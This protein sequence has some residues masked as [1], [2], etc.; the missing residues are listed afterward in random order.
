MIR[1][2]IAVA[3]FLLSA[4][5]MAAALLHAGRYASLCF[6]ARTPAAASAT[7]GEADATQ[8]AEKGGRASDAG[9]DSVSGSQPA[10]AD[11]AEAPAGSVAGSVAKGGGVAEAAA[12]E[13]RGT[14]VPGSVDSGGALS[15]AAPAGGARSDAAASAP[16]GGR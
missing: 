13:V 5:V 15:G 4:A 6:V 11:E 12:T 16:Q 1:K 8:A 7:N 10:A 3:V 2:Y 14:A 9:P